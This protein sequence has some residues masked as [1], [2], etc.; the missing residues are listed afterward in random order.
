[1]RG[2]G[3]TYSLLCSFGL[4]A[5]FSTQEQQPCPQYTAAYFSV[6]A[7]QIISFFSVFLPCCHPSSFSWRLSLPP[8]PPSLPPQAVRRSFASCVWTMRSW[9]LMELRWHTWTTPSGR[10]K[11]H[12]PCKPAVW[13]WTSGAMATRVRRCAKKEDIHVFRRPLKWFVII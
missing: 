9:L 2:G 1:M 8:S 11:W 6:C 12:L 3:V 5:Y 7:K 10:I 4:L 13:L